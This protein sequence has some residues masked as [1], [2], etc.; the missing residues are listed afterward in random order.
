MKH[1]SSCDTV[2]ERIFQSIVEDIDCGK[3]LPGARLSG[4][5]QLAEQYSAGRSSMIAAL[6][7]LQQ[8]GYIERLPMRGTF[9][10]K[11]VRKIATEVKIFCP[12]PEVMLP[13]NI[14]YAS[15]I[16]DTEITQGL[17]TDG[18]GKNFSVTFRH[19]EDSEDLLTLR[20]QLEFIQ[21]SSQA[22]VFIGH[23]FAHL[24]ELVFQKGI[25]AVV[26][27]PQFLWNRDR[28]P[29]ISYKV[30]EA[31]ESYADYIYDRGCRSLGLVSMLSPLESNRLDLELRLSICRKALI[32]KGIKIR[33][34]QLN[35]YDHNPSD[36]VYHELEQLLQEA[37]T[38]LPDTLC[39][40]HF[41]TVI[42][43]QQLLSERRSKVRLIAFTGGGIYSML[44]PRVPY[45]RIPCYKMGQLASNMLVEAVRAGTS[46]NDQTVQPVI[47]PEIN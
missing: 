26:I 34:Y 14:G 15:F 41:S 2:P 45:I 36:A 44:Y 25:P 29:N 42:A 7:L 1:H 17:I 24:K 3:L 23:Q 37:D 38:E 43:L 39:G 6:R 22:V 9:I 11:D 19:F 32:S 10:R 46:I 20:R 47:W 27:L 33:D 4:D 8:K 21:Q 13:E 28:L 35:T 40:I 16:V 12:L 31:F 30:E 5:R 18:S